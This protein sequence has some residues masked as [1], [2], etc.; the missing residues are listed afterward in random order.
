LACPFR[1]RHHDH[2]PDEIVC[3]SL[4]LLV[5]NNTKKGIVDFDS[6]VVFDKTELPEFVHEQIDP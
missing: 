1:N 5:Q 4:N 3:D 2:P 6:A